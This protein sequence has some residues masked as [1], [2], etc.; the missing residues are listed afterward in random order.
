MSRG[1]EHWDLVNLWLFFIVFFILFVKFY[2]LLWK[3]AQNKHLEKHFNAKS[4]CFFLLRCLVGFCSQPMSRWV[5]L[6]LC[7]W[8]VKIQRGILRDWPSVCSIIYDTYIYHTYIY[9]KY[10]YH[11]YAKSRISSKLFSFSPQIVFSA[12]W[13]YKGQ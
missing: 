5:I 2:K 4:M 12:Q 8:F 9:Q 6:L 7:Q 1:Q 11:G 13:R 3:E 10:I